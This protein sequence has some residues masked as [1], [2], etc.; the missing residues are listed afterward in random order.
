MKDKYY[1][2]ISLYV[3]GQCTTI[4]KVKIGKHLQTCDKCRERYQ[5][6]MA[7]KK[8]AQAF[9]SFHVS[10][11]FASKVVSMAKRRKQETFWNALEIIPRPLLNAAFIFSILIIAIVAM[12]WQKPTSVNDP[13]ANMVESSLTSENDWPE[14]DL[15]TN[16]EALQF[17]LNDFE[18]ARGETK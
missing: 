16:D 1:A 6:F 17:V 3:D 13:V 18:E 8:D 7:L 15:E 10:P 5:Q 14:P 2:K 11:F 9:K 12:P 4:E